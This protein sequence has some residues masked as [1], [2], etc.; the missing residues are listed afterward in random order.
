[1]DNP[2]VSICI[3]T[4]NVKGTQHDETYNNLTM[5]VDLFESIELQ[6]Y[7][8]YEV[9]VSDHS[10]DGSIE[11]VCEVWSDKINIKYFLNKKSI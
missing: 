7:T 11:E 8:N 3:P 5:L 2:L 1:M 10:K 9:V 4:Y 6:T